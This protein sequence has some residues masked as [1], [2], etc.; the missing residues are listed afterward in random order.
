MRDHYVGVRLPSE[1]VKRAKAVAAVD[2]RSLSNYILTLIERDVR[3]HDTEAS[4]IQES[5]S[6]YTAPRM[7]PDA[8]RGG[9]QK[10]SKSDKSRRAS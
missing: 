9:K 6:G 8:K 4:T 1:L 10:P 3:Q 7:L 5:G 2:R